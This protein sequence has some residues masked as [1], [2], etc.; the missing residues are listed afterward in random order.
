MILQQFTRTKSCYS[1]MKED[2]IEAVKEVEGTPSYD[3]LRPSWEA[4]RN[5]P[6]LER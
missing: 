3:R 6:H 2:N 4:A 5:L 1:A